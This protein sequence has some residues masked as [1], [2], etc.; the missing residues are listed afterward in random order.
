MSDFLAQQLTLIGNANTAELQ[1]IWRETFPEIPIPQHRKHVLAIMLAQ[2]LQEQAFGAM[3]PDLT[4]HL[5]RLA[6][7]V[8]NEKKSPAAAVPMLKPGTRLVRSWEG[9]NHVVTVEASG[10][11]YCGVHH[12]S[13]SQIARLITGTRWSGPLFFGLRSQ[14]TSEVKH[15]Q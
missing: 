5:R 8:D 14:R 7:T 12:K 15:G 3:R 6:R 2:K 9:Q 13:L 10:F 4:A 11:E 1:R